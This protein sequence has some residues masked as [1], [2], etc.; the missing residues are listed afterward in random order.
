MDRLQ[1]SKLV[2]VR[3]NTDTEIEPSIASVNDFVVSELQ[4]LGAG[5][6]S[7]GCS[8]IPRRSWTGASDHGVLRCDE[9]LLLY[10]S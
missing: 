1:I 2:I 5:F 9:P 6:D 7:L 4:E 3:V 8:I 10:E